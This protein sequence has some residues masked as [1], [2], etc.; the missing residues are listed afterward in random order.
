MIRHHLRELRDLCN[1]SVIGV[2]GIRPVLTGLV[3]D[4]QDWSIRSFVVN[5]NAPE[6]EPVVVPQSCFRSLD[7]DRRELRLDL[8]DQFLDSAERFRPEALVKST[9]FDAVTL[10][11]QTIDG[12]NGPAGKVSDLLI[13][14]DLWV[15]RYFVID[16]D[17]RRVLTDIEWA[18]SLAQGKE[19]LVVDLPAEAIATAPP[20]EH[21]SKLSTGDEE[22]LYRHYTRTAYICQDGVA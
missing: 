14:V 2:A 1:Y 11:G 8:D 17:S 12:R 7:D 18:S 22:A 6:R 13:N 3:F 5:R 16:T 21:L 9:K 15:L 19:R 4:A 10:I 20:Y